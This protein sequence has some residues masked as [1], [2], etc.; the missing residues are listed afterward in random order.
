MIVHSCRADPADHFLLISC[1]Q[2]QFSTCT[3]FLV[4]L[5]HTENAKKRVNGVGIVNPL[6]CRS[7]NFELLLSMY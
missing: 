4:I 3:D 2:Y 6:E 7:V 5:G 1:G